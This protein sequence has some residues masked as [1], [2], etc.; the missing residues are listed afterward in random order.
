MQ[1]IITRQKGVLNG[2]PR[3]RN[4]QIPVRKIKLFYK[5]GWPIKDIASMYE[6]S[7]FQ[8]KTAINYGKKYKIK[9]K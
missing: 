6:I 1:S 7:L 4:K 3:L 2:L 9:F 5:S 8:V